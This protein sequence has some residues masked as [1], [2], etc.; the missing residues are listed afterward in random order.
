MGALPPPS[1]DS[2][3]IAAHQPPQG[4]GRRGA[5]RPAVAGVATLLGEITVTASP[6]AQRTAPAADPR[7]AWRSRCPAHPHQQAQRALAGARRG[8]DGIRLAKEA[9][10]RAQEVL[11][12]HRGLGPWE[13]ARVSAG[14][15]LCTACRADRRPAMSQVGQ[16][17]YRTAMDL[18]SVASQLTADL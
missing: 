1:G 15:S 6:A 5:G 7:A 12:L 17:A 11:A 13:R 18:E 2:R 8:P 3:G 9:L 4:Q 10:H 14:G 16:R